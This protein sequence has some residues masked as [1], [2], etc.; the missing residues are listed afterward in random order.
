[1]HVLHS[2]APR[3][4]LSLLV[5]S[6]IAAIAC[7]QDGSRRP[8]AEKPSTGP[9]TGAVTSPTPAQV[10]SERIPE[11]PTEF[12]SVLME[13]TF[14]I[15]GPGA[16]QGS[17]SFGTCFILGRP[18]K[19]QPGKLRYVLVT[20]A[21][22]LDNIK[23]DEALLHLRKRTA[24]GYADL[25]ARFKIRANG[26]ALWT[27]HADPQVD[28]AVTYLGLPD[29]AYITK[30]P[31]VSTDLLVDDYRL[32]ALDVHP[33]DE[34]LCLGF[35][36]GIA[37]GP[38]FFPVLRS[39]K[40]ASY[41]VVPTAET[42]VMLFDF[43]VFPGNSGGPVY[44]DQTARGVHGGLAVGTQRFIAGLVTQSV[45]HASRVQ[46]QNITLEQQES[47]DLGVVIHAHFIREAL[48]QLPKP[49]AN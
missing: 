13:A 23:A 11:P 33:G 25:P 29:E 1:M 48:E 9:G 15:E 47:L 42:K 19:E 22:V 8:D 30:V 27:H 18:L 28:V 41:P 45:F 20:A 39:G 21:H 12:N 4:C 26:K 32:R 37:V 49:E 24:S 16:V 43:H 38:G 40:I 10:T 6:A 7:A 46:G 17:T 31:L 3:A 44:F 14:K 35:P 2:K 36:H 5:A 34:L